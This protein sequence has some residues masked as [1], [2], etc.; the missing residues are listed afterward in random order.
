MYIFDEPI[1]LHQ[2]EHSVGNSCAVVQASSRD[3]K[4]ETK[5]KLTHNLEEIPSPIKKVK[6]EEEEEEEEAVM[7]LICI[8][9]MSQK[10]KKKNQ[11]NFMVEI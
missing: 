6:E 10:K 7:N 9:N 3:Q 5:M 4:Y 2:P 1:S 8:Y 11:T